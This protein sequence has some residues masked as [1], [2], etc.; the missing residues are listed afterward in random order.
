M[1][2]NYL[3]VA[4]RNT[5]KNRVYTLINVFGL[6]TGIAAVLLIFIYIYNEFQ[7]DKFLTKRDRIYR[8]EPSFGQATIPSLPGSILMREQSYC[9][10][11][12]RVFVD[13]NNYS[14]NYKN[15][16]YSF[17][18]LALAD[19]SFF[20]LFDLEFVL[21]NP[22]K[23]LII[24]NSLVIVESQARIMFGD[25][26]PLGKTIFI[27]N[28]YPFTITGVIKDPEKFHLQV[29][30]VGTIESLREITYKD[31]LEQFDGWN[32]YTYVLGEKGLSGKE[33]EKKVN[34]KLMEYDYKYFVKFS[35][36]S[37][38]DLYFAKPLVNEGI[39][40]HGNKPML[41]ILGTIALFLL[42]IAWI[43]FVN[44]ATA[45]ASNRA[46]EVGIRKVVG[47]KKRQLI[48]QFFLETVIIT[49]ISLFLAAVIIESI[50]IPFCNLIG[51]SINFNIL[52]YP[53]ILLSVIGFSLFTGCIAGLYPALWL[54]TYA[55]IAVLKSKSS[56]RLHSTFLQKGMIVFQYVI[57]IM[58]IASTMIIYKQLHYLKSF[59]LGFDKEHVVY[60]KINDEILQKQ[61]LFKSELLK[62]PEIQKVA[63]SGRIMGV[64]WGNWERKVG[65]KERLDFQQN[66]IDPDYFET[67]GIQLAQ[68]RNFKDEIGDQNSNYILNE[69][70]IKTYD[71]KEVIGTPVSDD[72]QA[73]GNI[74]GIVKD[75]HFLSPRI[76][77]S[78]IMF[79]FDKH[80]YNYVNIRISS[81]DIQTTIS[82]IGKVWG[83]FCPNFVFESHFLDETYD[84]QYRSDNLLGKLIGTGS[85]L[86]IIIACLGILGLALSSTEYHTKEIGIR[87]VNGATTKQIILMLSKDPVKWVSVSLILATPL[88]YYV[89]DKWLQNF[90]SRTRVNG[91]IFLL[92]GLITFLIALA[93]VSWQ[94]WQ[95]AKRD[96]VEA[97]RYE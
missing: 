29:K 4:I 14:V 9:E 74:I 25:E 85:V 89:M 11:V 70:A 27:E 8:I 63:Y 44:I 32:F 84:Y 42:A 60:L 13:N 7:Y 47:A 55:P 58:L 19:S 20:D 62:I 67:M 21:G 86:A 12:V 81:T 10:R 33:L 48:V 28:K 61:D 46:R 26:N 79:Y 77:V 51:K 35:L 88:A 34:D 82:K 31:I 71:L 38:H 2:R 23:S 54:S 22:R 75:F 76:G 83:N 49:I 56:S 91:W 6:T 97:L 39:T 43:N 96:P 90:A 93:T 68:G 87:K 69:A 5:S 52:Y 53:E 95:A 17:N 16:V 30:G 36:T 15:N 66:F 64:E 37:L 92:A 24:P 78:P 94:S 45:R 57:A 65:D 40:L 3:K 73:A 80:Y 50:Q 72:G 1:L 41:F 59:D 18:N